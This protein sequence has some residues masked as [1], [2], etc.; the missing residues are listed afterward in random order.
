MPLV[1]N[2]SSKNKAKNRRTEI[3]ITPDL[4]EIANLISK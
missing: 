3:I 2:S 1:E 4:S